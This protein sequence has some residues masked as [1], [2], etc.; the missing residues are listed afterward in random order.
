EQEGTYPLPE[1]QR[2]RFMF[3]VLVDYPRKG[4]EREIIARTTGAFTA[5]VKPV[6]TGKEII[7]CQELVRKVP[8]PDHVTNYVLDLVRRARPDDAEALDLAKEYISWG[9]GPRACQMLI[10]GGKVRAV[11][12]GRFHVTV[13]D[14]VALAH[15]VL[16]HRI[17]LTFHAEAEN[18]SVEHIITKLIEQVPREQADE[19][20]KIGAS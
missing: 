10:L 8:V 4:E 14:I 1:A 16:R 15:P 17:L 2:D 13:D 7:R 20:I 19:A 5:E 9:P 11:L 18:I 12:Q 6:I 3:K